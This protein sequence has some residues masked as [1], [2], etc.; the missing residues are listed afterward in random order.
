GYSGRA[1]A[2]CI[3]VVTL[4]QDQRADGREADDRIEDPV[5]LPQL[6]DAV[7]GETASESSP[8]QGTLHRIQ[9]ENIPQW[10]GHKAI[11]DQTP[12]VAKGE[13]K[14]GEAGKK[15]P[16]FAKPDPIGQNAVTNIDLIV[17]HLLGEMAGGEDNSEK[18]A[19]ESPTQVEST[20][21]GIAHQEVQ[22]SPRE[23]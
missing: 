11:L 4:L 14:Q 1:A 21:H 5:G 6:A 16:S 22:H 9:Q 8:K 19:D 2:G 12:E 3:C 13:C 10:C 7:E 18:E 23:V 17:P 15:Y 20:H